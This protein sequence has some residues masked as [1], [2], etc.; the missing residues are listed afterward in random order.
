MKEAFRRA[1]VATARYRIATTLE[2]A[3]ES[4][5]YTHL[6]VYKRQALTDGPACFR[7]DFSCLAVLR[8]P[9]GFLSL[10]YTGLAPSAV[11]LSISFY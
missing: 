9:L 10:S 11:D 2:D 3:I 1:N 5:S 6:D 4:V 8:I 7:Q